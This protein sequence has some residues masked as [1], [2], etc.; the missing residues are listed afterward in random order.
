M[1][2]SPQQD[3]AI[4]A[5][6]PYYVYEHIR[7]DT[8]K[9]FYVGKGKG[10]RATVTQGRNPKW[11]DI[12][13]RCGFKARIVV[14]GVDE[15]FAYLAEIELIDLRRRTGHSLANITDG[16]EDFSTGMWADSEVRARHSKAQSK[17]WSSSEQRSA[18]SVRLRAAY[19]NHDL[20]SKIGNSVR[21]AFADPA[22]KERLR[23]GVA[24][25][26][27]TDE[28]RAKASANMKALL[29]DPKHL[30]RLRD[31]GRRQAVSVL[32]VETGERFE[33]VAD[34]VSWLHRLGHKKATDAAIAH[35]C[36]GRR[37]TAYGYRWQRG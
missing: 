30:Q 37:K 16:G 23:S 6:G 27:R 28:A 25:A 11:H 14:Q 19:E 34:A 12:A 1:S 3:A 29:Q 31:N 2:W 33:A 36:S 4:K 21:S 5:D 8:G 7:L 9:P 32:C 22:T 26:K 10:G 20:R 18:Q 17:R 15:E 13:D 24:R 35:A